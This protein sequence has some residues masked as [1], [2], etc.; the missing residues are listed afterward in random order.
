[1]WEFLAMGGKAAYVWP[2]F[3]ISAVAIG[4]LVAW[5]YHRLRRA[6]EMLALL[7]EDKP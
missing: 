2:S 6:K 5:S 7:E 3:L 4:A 1:M